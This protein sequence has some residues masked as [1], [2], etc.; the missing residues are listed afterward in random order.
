MLN[1]IIFVL[2]IHSNVVFVVLHSSG[3]QDSKVVWIW[4]RKVNILH[5]CT[6]P[7]CVINLIVFV[8]HYDMFIATSATIWRNIIISL[9]KG[10]MKKIETLFYIN[11]NYFSPISSTIINFYHFSKERLMQKV[12]E[13]KKV[14]F[15]SFHYQDYRV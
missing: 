5:I 12:Y 3:S 4:K 13:T 7:L 6:T 14:L 1:V 10:K 8:D 15:I 11:Y 2:L 9:N